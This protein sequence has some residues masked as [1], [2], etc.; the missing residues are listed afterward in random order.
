LTTELSLFHAYGYM[1][2]IFPTFL[3]LDTNGYKNSLTATELYFTPCCT[4]I[5]NAYEEY[6]NDI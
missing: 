3:K 1:S 5:C 4:Y 2:Y 6:L